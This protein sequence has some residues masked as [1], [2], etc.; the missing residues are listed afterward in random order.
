MTIDLCMAYIFMLVSMTLTLK[1]SPLNWLVLFSFCLPAYLPARPLARSSVC[2]FLVVRLSVFLPVSVIQ[3]PWYDLRGWMGVKNQLSIYLSGQCG[4]SVVP[5]FAIGS[6]RMIFG[7]RYSG[8]FLITIKGCGFCWF[9]QVFT[10]RPWF[11]VWFYYNNCGFVCVFVYLPL[12]SLC[13][14]QIC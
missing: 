4:S 12:C 10:V 13:T 5:L 1:G 3:S 7:V 11:S 8:I 14:A 9:C 2:V 6:W